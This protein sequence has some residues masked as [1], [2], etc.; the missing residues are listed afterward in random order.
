[1]KRKVAINGFGRIGRSVLKNILRKKISGEL[2]VVAINDLADPET[3][4]HLLRYDSVYGMY[5][6]GAKYEKD[7]LQIDGVM[8]GTD[9]KIFSEKDPSRLPW[10]ELGVDVVLECTGFFTDYDG[11]KKHLDAGAKTVVISAPSK[12]PEKIP[13]F[14]LGVNEK[15]FDVNLHKIVDMGSCTTNCLAP[16]VKILHENYGVEKGMMTTIHSYTAN[17]NLLDG[18]HKDLRR[19]RAAALSIIP[20]TTGATKAI[21][22]VLPE[23]EGKLTGLSIRVPTPTVSLIDLVCLLQEEVTVEDLNYLLKQQSGKEE[24][25]GILGV[26]DAKLVSIDYVGSSF[27]G[28]VDCNMTEAQGSLVKLIAWY[29]NEWGYAARLADFCRYIAQKL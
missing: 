8:G 23:L 10:G 21:G 20:T 27:S 12:D 24:L 9:I 1:M 4:T 16:I 14:I 11:A 17:Q 25:R 18:P 6:K 13:S 15:D 3:L 28:V 2:E 19:A 5:E 7:L 29:D 22:R 26:E